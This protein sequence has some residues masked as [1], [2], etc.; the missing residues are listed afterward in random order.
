VRWGVAVEVFGQRIE[1]GQLI[2][3]DKHGFLALTAEEAARALEAALF[4][5]ANECRTVIAAARGAAGRPA[6]E[7]LKAMEEAAAAFGKA[8]REKFRKDG[9][10]NVGRA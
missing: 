6:D 4:M 3:A 9:E 5:D 10:W 7:A 8:T 2:H 1:P